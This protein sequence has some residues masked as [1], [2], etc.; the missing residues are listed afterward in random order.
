MCPENSIIIFPNTQFKIKNASKIH[1]AAFFVALRLQ[2]KCCWILVFVVWDF[3]FHFLFFLNNTSKDKCSNQSE[4]SCV[5]EF[6]PRN[7]NG[8]VL[9]KHSRHAWKL[10]HYRM[11]SSQQLLYYQTA[12]LHDAHDFTLSYFKVLLGQILP[13]EKHAQAP[14]KPGSGT[15]SHVSKS[16]ICTQCYKER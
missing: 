12:H 7:R 8:I 16:R 1:T 15:Y 4:I 10:M 11:F 9:N 3:L 5:K 14:L 13:L 2:F 6:G